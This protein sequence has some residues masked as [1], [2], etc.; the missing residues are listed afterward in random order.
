MVRRWHFDI[1]LPQTNPAASE[2]SII[3][4]LIPETEMPFR[5]VNPRRKG[6]M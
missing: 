5:S 2:K 4:G 3:I 1:S 6:N